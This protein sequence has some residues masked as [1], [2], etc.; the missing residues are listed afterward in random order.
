M[1][2]CGQILEESYSLTKALS[3]FRPGHKQIWYLYLE[4]LM[5]EALIVT[6]DMKFITSQLEMW[7]RAQNAFFLRF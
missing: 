6:E 2:I 7:S 5:K 4:S 1:T 3:N